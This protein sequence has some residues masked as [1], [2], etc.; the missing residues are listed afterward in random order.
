MQGV[1][2]KVR[3]V[4]WAE[5]SFQELQEKAKSWDVQCWSKY[6]VFI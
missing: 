3:G 2:S 1:R 4:F 5:I 6:N